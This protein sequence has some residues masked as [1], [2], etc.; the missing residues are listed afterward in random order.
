[1]DTDSLRTM[2]GL[3]LPGL[4]LSQPKLQLLLCYLALEGPRPRRELA[5]LFWGGSSEPANRLAVALNRIRASGPGLVGADV[6]QV[7]TPLRA[8]ASRLRTLLYEGRSDEATALYRGH[9][10]QGFRCEGMGEELEEWVFA[11]REE[12]AR[13]LLSARLAQA[14]R[15]ALREQYERAARLAE[16]ALRL[17]EVALPEREELQRLYLILRAAGLVPSPALSAELTQAVIPALK[18]EEARTALH[19]AA[20]PILHNLPIAVKSFTGREAERAELTRLLAGPHSRL[21]TLA[22]PGGIG[23]SRLALTVGWERLEAGA[24][25]DGVYWVDLEPLTS[26]AAIPGVIAEALGTVVLGPEPLGQLAQT[27]KSKRLLLILDNFEHLAEG[28]SP[29]TTLLRSCP[30]LRILATSRER[31]GLQEEWL[32]PLEGLAYPSDPKLG[33]QEIRQYPAVQLFL[34]RTAQNNPRF[35]PAEADAAP[36]VRICA[37]AAGS[38]LALELAAGWMGALG[39]EELGHMTDNLETFSTTLRNVPERHRSMR[40]VL[41]QS[42]NVLSPEEQMALAQLSV[43]QG[44]FSI[45][46]AQEVA[47]VG[48]GLLTGLL[49]KSLIRVLPAGRYDCHPLLHVFCREKAARYPDQRAAA[50][51]RHAAYFSA[52]SRDWAWR[53]IGRELQQATHSFVQDYE[54]LKAA[55]CWASK[56]QQLELLRGLLRGF[57]GYYVNRFDV[58]EALKTWD[59]AEA[60]LDQTN[61]AHHALLGELLAARALSYMTLKSKEEV[62]AVAER[63]LELLRPLGERWG[64]RNC[65]VALTYCAS[66]PEEAERYQREIIG[67]GQAEH[68]GMQLSNLSLLKLRFGQYE[69]AKTAFAEA[70]G[71]NRQAGD[72]PG[73]I[74]CLY[75]LGLANL[76]THSPATAYAWFQQASELSGTTVSFLL[77]GNAARVGMAR[78]ALEMGDLER[79]EQAAQAVLERDPPLPFENHTAGAMAI[80]V[81]VAQ[82]RGNWAQGRELCQPMLSR[83]W[84]SLPE[85]DEFA[86]LAL[87]IAARCCADSSLLETAVQTLGYIATRHHA[88]E[89]EEARYELEA[90]R[91]KLE[92]GQLEF[93][94]E[95]GHKLTMQEV[96]STMLAGLS[97][98]VAAG[99][100]QSGELLVGDPRGDLLG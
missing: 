77:Y 32:L 51:E 7:W 49:A 22:G 67:L 20:R 55:W 46:A 8:D 26:P 17:L 53:M 18:P 27:L 96:V 78:A 34:E 57:N 11:T 70:L 65:L 75:H 21:L 9:F 24:F 40:T 41:E 6:A 45:E 84:L 71:V 60:I 33:L 83:P 100:P 28:A 85:P 10:L 92:P 79:A 2:G 39:I 15:L 30:E 91:P 42:W 73:V 63:G 74:F 56:H 59:I 62:V 50:E 25:P 37:F 29:L 5:G 82:G 23:K 68:P 3:E 19:T 66:T 87:R 16:E 86:L 80:R 44:G 61:P 52:K 98:V 90:L 31:L 81:A 69:A 54:N 36:L 76:Y 93:A 47:A 99:S 35:H 95:R 89:G 43:F 88:F 13:R 64:I 58:M 48:V 12:L 4:H 38:P 94:L 14:E 97:A 1:M 72:D